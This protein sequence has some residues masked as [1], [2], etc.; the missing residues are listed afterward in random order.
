MM[1][2]IK[3]IYVALLA[4]ALLQPCR[5]SAQKTPVCQMERIG[6]GVVALPARD[7]GVFLSWRLL[8]TDSQQTCFDV[9]RDGKVIA[10]HIRKTNFTDVQGSAENTY[11]I[12]AITCP[13]MPKRWSKRT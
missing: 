1:K 12:S 11:R 8:G 2:P 7:K 6:R 3:T 13:T 5:A 9:E 10:H 4:S